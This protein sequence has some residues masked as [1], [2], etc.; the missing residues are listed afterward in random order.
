[1]DAAERFVLFEAD[2]G[3][4]SFLSSTAPEEVVA[5]LR[6]ASAPP[7]DPRDPRLD[8]VLEAFRSQWRRI[9]RRKCPGLLED[10]DDA[11][12]NASLK[13]LLPRKLATLKDPT[14]IETWARTLFLNTLLDLAA[15]RQREFSRR[16]TL[17]GPGDD[18]EE[19]LRDRLPST[20]PS[21][22][23][24]VVHRER[25]RF[26]IEW[27]KEFEIMQLK[28][29]GL[30]DKEIADLLGLTPNAVRQQLKRRREDLKRA[31]GK[32]EEPDG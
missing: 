21:L 16:A 14:R 7:R 26:V 30:P 25:A 11:I 18:P 27:I 31:L 22:E 28:S 8:D 2:A 20:G 12:Q 29:R 17:G 4:G 1:L 23:E 15:D 32:L 13:L 3:G 10:V 6:S 5:I 24:E 9:A 19:F